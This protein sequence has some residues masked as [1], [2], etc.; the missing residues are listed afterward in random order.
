MKSVD[1]AIEKDLLSFPCRFEIKVVG[2]QSVNFGAR[3]YSVIDRHLGNTRIMDIS[4]RCSRKGKYL[5]LTC[6]IKAVSREQ[7]DSIYFDLNREPDV[8]MIL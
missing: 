3:I 7:L 5:S 6:V 8:L 1:A 4:S 2:R